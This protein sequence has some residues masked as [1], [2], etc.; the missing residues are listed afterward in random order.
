[1]G[2]IIMANGSHLFTI[3]LSVILL[4]VLAPKKSETHEVLS[5]KHLVVPQCSNI[6]SNPLNEMALI[7]QSVYCDQ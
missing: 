3:M 6:V 5:V 7:L 4:N 1:M 2:Y